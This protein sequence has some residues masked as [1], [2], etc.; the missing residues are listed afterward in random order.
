MAASSAW[1]GVNEV[2]AAIGTIQPPIA[3]ATRASVWCSETTWSERSCV[4]RSYS[5]AS[6]KSSSPARPSGADWTI[7]RPLDAITCTTAVQENTRPVSAA[8]DQNAG[9]EPS[10]D[11]Q[12]WRKV[13]GVSTK[14]HSSVAAAMGVHPHSG[15]VS[16]PGQA[17]G[18]EKVSCTWDQSRSAQAAQKAG[19]ARS[20]KAARSSSVKSAASTRISTVPSKRACVRYATQI[21]PSAACAQLKMRL[22]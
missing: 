18:S 1:G 11:A 20:D 3:A 17:A 5:Q 13:R 2:H 21:T 15:P 22:K 10:S 12:A 14:M 6:A 9:S 19:R 4:M 7:V 8:A 16:A